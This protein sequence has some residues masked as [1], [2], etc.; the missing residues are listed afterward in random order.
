MICSRV[1]EAFTDY[2]A[3]TLSAEET[4]EA[5]LH[6]RT[7]LACQ[8]DWA[9]WQET[10]L[11][12][13]R[14]PAEEPSPRLRENFYAMLDTHQRAAE[15]GPFAQ[16]RTQLDRICARLLPARPAW[17]LA[18]AL[19]LLAVGVFVG[20]FFAGR[21]APVEPHDAALQRQLAELQRKV[22]SMGQLVAYS[23][24]RPQ[25]ANAR[26]QQVA[27]TRQRGGADAETLAGLVRTLAFDPSTNVRL[28]AL[29]TLY[30]Y[31]DLPLVREGV[32][33]SLPREGSPLVQLAM[34]DFLVSLRDQEAAPAFE[35]LTRDAAVDQ[36]VRAAARRAL[37]QL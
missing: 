13:D 31:A 11:L 1:Q 19:A 37:V 18:G 12:L 23:L 16:L 3:G 9:G 2:Q 28:S 14:L 33:A 6:L 29:E 35:A 36:A 34:I 4:A 30:A 25:P 10:L 20:V 15:A 32:L 7:C 21:P 22:D 5:R 24:V 17:Q 8:R 26:L 27:A